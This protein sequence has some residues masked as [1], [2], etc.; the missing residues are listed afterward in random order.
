MQLQQFDQKRLT[1][2]EKE[3]RQ[4]PEDVEKSDTKEA[5]DLSNW[6]QAQLG[7]KAAKVKITNRLASHPCVITGAY[8]ERAG[9]LLLSFNYLQCL[10][11][12]RANF[13]KENFI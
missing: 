5:M 10:T 6:I 3:F 8:Y 12:S 11:S 7:S 9:N 1:S 13:T 2:V 4:S